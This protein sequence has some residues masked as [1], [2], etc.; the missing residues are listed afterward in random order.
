[1]MASMETLRVEKRVL[2]MRRI[3]G[4]IK[5]SESDC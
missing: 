4:K 5:I 2:G 1:L 3:I